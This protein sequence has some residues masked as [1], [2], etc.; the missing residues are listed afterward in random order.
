MTQDEIIQLAREAGFSVMTD[1]SKLE[2]VLCVGRHPD[3]LKLFAELVAAKEREKLLAE[4][5]YLGEQLQAYILAEREACA[6]VCDEIA[7]RAMKKGYTVKG[8]T[9]IDGFGDGAGSCAAEIRTR[10]EK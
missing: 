4:N 9:F 8:E 3:S 2:D 6:K 1:A 5:S 7:D 10:G